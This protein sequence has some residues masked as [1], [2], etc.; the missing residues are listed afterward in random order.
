MG[1][2]VLKVVNLLFR[3]LKLFAHAKR[4]G[5]EPGSL[6]CGSEDSRKASNYKLVSDLSFATSF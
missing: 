3:F 5:H 1:V 6:S 2:K 4:P